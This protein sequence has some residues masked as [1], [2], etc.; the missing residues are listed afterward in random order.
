M[1]FRGV[2]ITYK[3]LSPNVS[4][5]AVGILQGRE[6]KYGSIYVNDS[7]VLLRPEC[8]EI[9]YTV[10]ATD[11]Q[12]RKHTKTLLTVVLEGT[13]KYLSLSNEI[14]RAKFVFIRCSD[15]DPTATDICPRTSACK[16]VYRMGF[17]MLIIV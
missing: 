3:L 11:K 13:G 4:C 12:S 7:S 9:Q 8:K 6:D 10:Q 17:L 2:N 1:K 14:K 16:V 15:S 5:Y